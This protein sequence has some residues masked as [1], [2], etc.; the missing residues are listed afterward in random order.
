L[1]DLPDKK[2][3]L[4]RKEKILKKVLT[5]NEVMKIKIEEKNEETNTKKIHPSRE[6]ASVPEKGLSKQL[7]KYTIFQR[8]FHN[9]SFSNS[10]SNFLSFI[11]TKASSTH[12]SAISLEKFKNLNF[13]SETFYISKQGMN[14]R[15]KIDEK[16]SNILFSDSKTKKCLFLFF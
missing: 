11:R 5:S 7:V 13:S 9:C 3:K 14:Q 1:A 15:P 10:N 2:E 8:S 12:K 4:S 16:K 6:Q